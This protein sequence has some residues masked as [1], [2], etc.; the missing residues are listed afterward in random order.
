MD[1]IIIKQIANPDNPNLPAKYI[2]S[3]EYATPK[4]GKDGKIITGIDENSYN[5]ISLE[6]GDAKKKSAEVRKQRE[7]LEKLL[8]VKLTPDSDFWKEFFV[9]LEEDRIL[10]PQNPRD[11]L[12]EKFLIANRYVAP[13]LESVET[14]PDYY[15]CLFYIHREKEETS[16]KAQNQRK[17]DKAISELYILAEKNPNKLQQVSAD[18]FGYNAEEV[19]SDEAYVKLK[20]YL[21]VTDEKLRKSNISRFL[22]TIEKTPEQMMIKKIFDKSLKK[23]FISARGGIY[24]RGDQV[25]GNNYEEALEFLGL[26]ENSSELLSLKKEVD[27]S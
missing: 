19:S 7:N 20:E 2:G 18:I 25:L 5:I 22:D 16:K 8:N 11:I 12:H 14:D 3:K 23:R 24:R 21:E 26:P 13:S 15:N 6:D 4:T 27:R 9:V 1:K 10:D 17:I